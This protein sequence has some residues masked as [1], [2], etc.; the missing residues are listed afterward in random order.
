[1]I[2]LLVGKASFCR[3][4]RNGYEAGHIW[5]KTKSQQLNKIHETFVISFRLKEL[6]EWMNEQP[7]STAGRQ[8]CGTLAIDEALVDR[9]VSI[10]DQQKKENRQTVYKMHVKPHLVSSAQ[11]KSTRNLKS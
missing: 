8:A 4:N 11:V 1:M 2:S 9:I 7:F 3:S 6:I 10:V 5:H